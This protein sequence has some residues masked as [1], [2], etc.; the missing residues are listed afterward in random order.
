ME[1]F[2]AWILVWSLDV[3]KHQSSD[4]KSAVTTIESFLYAVSWNAYKCHCQQKSLL[5]LPAFE[6]NSVGATFAIVLSQAFTMS[7]DLQPLQGGWLQWERT[8]SHP[9]STE[10]KEK[11][12]LTPWIMESCLCYTSFWAIL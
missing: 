6:I 1:I 9:K 3:N 4:W 8:A 5:A 10:A 7:T 11:V 12:L 2:T